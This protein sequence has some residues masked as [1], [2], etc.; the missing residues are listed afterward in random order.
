MS[1]VSIT[2]GFDPIERR[3][4]GELYWDAFGA[5]LGRLMGPDESAIA[6]L[7]ANAHPNFAICA[8]DTSGKLL[9]IAGFKTANGGLIGGDFANFKA[10]YG[11][12]GSLWRAP[13]LS[14]LD[15]QIE[16]STFLMDG[17]C[18]ASEARGQGIG[19][20]LLDAIVETARSTDATQIRLDVIDNNPRAHALYERYGFVA[21]GTEDIGP[22]RHLFN[23]RTST[24]MFLDIS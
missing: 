1:T 24:T 2:Y 20:L 5:K 23:F 22:L 18:V 19:T 13:L 14:L 10:I 7:A 3:T 4:I 9:G 12:W 8:R 21:A 6:F 11:F 15:R 17:I 16:T